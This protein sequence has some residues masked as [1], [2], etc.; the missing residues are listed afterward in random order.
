MKKETLSQ[1][2]TKIIKGTEVKMKRVKAEH[3]RY[4]SV[5]GLEDNVY[6][7]EHPPRVRVTARIWQTIKDVLLTGLGFANSLPL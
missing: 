3:E 7:E 1:K 5:F 6:D 4:Y 2:K